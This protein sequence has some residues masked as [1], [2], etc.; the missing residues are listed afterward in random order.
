VRVVGFLAF[1]ATHIGGLGG[2]LAALH[3]DVSLLAALVAAALK[4]KIK[5]DA[6]CATPL[7]GLRPALPTVG[8]DALAA[9]EGPDQDADRF[10]VAHAPQSLH[11]PRIVRARKRTRSLNT[12]CGDAPPQGESAV[13]LCH[14]FRTAIYLP[15]CG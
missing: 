10:R 5:L 11:R 3:A 1:D 2:V 13:A 8:A 14:K 4:L 12:S 9:A 6:R 7:T 15:A